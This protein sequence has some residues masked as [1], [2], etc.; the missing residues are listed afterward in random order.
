MLAFFGFMSGFAQIISIDAA[1]E[2]RAEGYEE[3]ASESLGGL[4]EILLAIF[5]AISL[6]TGNCSH[7]QTVGQLFHDIIAWFFGG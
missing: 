6:L 4:G 2:K 3:L 1:I 5:M 7:I